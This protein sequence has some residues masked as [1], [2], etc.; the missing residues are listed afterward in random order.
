[1]LKGK[2]I[3]HIIK[4]VYPNSIAEELEI[5]VGDSLIRINDELIEDVF[6]YRYYMKD[7]YVEVFIRK[8]IGEEWILEID[9][10]YDEELGI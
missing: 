5:E 2:N 4:E 6:D 3:G 7:E 1:M 9:K 8:A 10:E